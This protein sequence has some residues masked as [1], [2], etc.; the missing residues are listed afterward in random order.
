[1][2]AA[3]TRWHRSPSRAP[4][5]PGGLCRA[6]RSEGAGRTRSLGKAVFEQHPER[7]DTVAPGNLLAFVVAAAVVGD[8]HFVDAITPLEDLRRDL[9]LD[10]EAVALEPE[11]PQHLDPHR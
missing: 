5:R 2:R 1:M 6:L 8:R 9:R 3:P 7:D 10:A 11:R 4:P